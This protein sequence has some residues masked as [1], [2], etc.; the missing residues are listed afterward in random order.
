MDRTGVPRE[1]FLT[2]ADYK[3]WSAGRLED[4]T[5]VELERISSSSGVVLYDSST[6]LLARVSLAWVSKEERL[7]PTSSGDWSGMK[8]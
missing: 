4:I 5:S 7:C 2:A 8:D 1:N 3:D 6:S